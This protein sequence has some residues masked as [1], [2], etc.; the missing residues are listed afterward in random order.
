M[1]GPS[2]LPRLTISLLGQ[3]P[4]QQLLLVLANGVAKCLHS[5]KPHFQISGFQPLSF[6]LANENPRFPMP[7]VRA[8]LAIKPYDEDDDS[9][10]DI[11]DTWCLWDT[12]AQT[13]MILSQ[14]LSEEV[15]GGQKEGYA[16]LVIRYA[17]RRRFK[18]LL[19]ERFSLDLLGH[20]STSRLRLALGQIYQT[21]P[22]S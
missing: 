6:P 21:V 22:I 20:H 8:D 19:A 3:L 13:L 16:S 12:G 4:I 15:R 10:T 7:F 11:Y 1:A 17:S 14:M 2:A 18:G 9:L 5:L